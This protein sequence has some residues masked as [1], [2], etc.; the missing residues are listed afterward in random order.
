M[1][2]VL[3]SKDLKFSKKCLLAKN[4]AN[5][6]FSI[7]NRGVSYKSTEVISKLYRSYFRPHIEYCIYF[8]T[9][10]NVKDTDM[11]E[12]VQRRATK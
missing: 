9:P 6:M 2:T 8:W 7:I 3:M 11:L 4:K 5:L 12:G 1:K 10:I